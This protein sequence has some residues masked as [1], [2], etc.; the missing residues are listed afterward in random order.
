MSKCVSPYY[1]PRARWYRFGSGLASELRRTFHLRRNRE[2]AR[3]SFWAIVAGFLVP[4][5]GFKARFPR[6]LGNVALA[7][8]FALLLIFFAWLGQ[9]VSNLAFGLLL[10]VHVMGSNYLVEPFLA[11]AR[12]GFRIV[13][14]LSWCFILLTLVYLPARDLLQTHWF[15]PIQVNG[16]VIVIDRGTSLENVKRGEWIAYT[17][18]ERYEAGIIVQAGYSFGPALALPGDRVSFTKSGF[19][20]NGIEQPRHDQMPGEGELILP[21]KRWFVWPELAKLGHGHVEEARISATFVQLA[22]VSDERF[23]GKP[24]KRWFWR[25]QPF[26]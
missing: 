9:P 16:Q 5:W 21:E 6:L 17:V 1:P 12:I 22:L 23:A 24:F 11:E 20:V 18:S 7:F 26:S 25:R 10:S 3:P 14:G 4:G 15:F 13:F 2:I 8:C 19:Q